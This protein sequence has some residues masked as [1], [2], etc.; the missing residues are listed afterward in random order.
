MKPSMIYYGG[1]QALFCRH[2][3]Q[4][5]RAILFGYLLAFLS[6]VL[7]GLFDV[8]LF[9][10]RVNVLSWTLLSSIH[11]LSRV[12]SRKADALATSQTLVTTDN[13]GQT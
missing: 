3:S 5:Q 11:V 8:V 1:I 6:C 12:P 10:S 7:Y 13:S 2:Y 9:D 4:A